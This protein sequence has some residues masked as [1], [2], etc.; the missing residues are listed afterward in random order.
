MFERTAIKISCWMVRNKIIESDRIMV[1]KWGIRSILDTIFNIM[2]FLIIGLFMRMVTE[3]IVF[4]LGYIPLRSY[5][6][7]YHAKTPLR[8]WI[9]SNLILFVAMKMICY[10][11]NFTSIFVFLAI[12]SVYIL[13]VLMPVSDIHKPLNENDKNKYKLI[14]VVILAIEITITIIFYIIAWENMVYCFFSVWIILAVM[15]IL[16]KLKNKKKENST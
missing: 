12:I 3:I 6:G 9:I 14:G 16:G 15:L 11:K 7:G 5:A 10:M 1:V 2:T 8:C 13:I 4:T